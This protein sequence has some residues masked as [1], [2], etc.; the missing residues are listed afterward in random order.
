MNVTQEC[1]PLGCVP[2]AVVAI[3]GGDLPQCMLGYTHPWVWA[4]RP[5]PQVWAW[6]P[7]ARLLNFPLGCEPG[8]SP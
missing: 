1:I 5:P 2:P 7:Q 3:K 4:W 6:T 8:D